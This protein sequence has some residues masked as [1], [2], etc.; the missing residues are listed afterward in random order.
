[1][2]TQSTRSLSAQFHKIQQQ[3]DN[4]KPGK[5]I[6]NTKLNGN[7]HKFK[8]QSHGKSIDFNGPE[9]LVDSFRQASENGKQLEDKYPAHKEFFERIAKLHWTWIDQMP[10][11]S[12]RIDRLLKLDD[13]E[14]NQVFVDTLIRDSHNLLNQ[15]LDD[16]AASLDNGHAKQIKIVKRLIYQAHDNY[17]VLFNLLFSILEMVTVQKYGQSR[18]ATWNYNPSLNE[19]KRIN[20]QIKTDRHKQF[21]RLLEL[22][23][24][25]VLSGLYKFFDFNSYHLQTMPYSRHTVEHGKFDPNNYTFTEFMQLVLLSRNIA[26]SLKGE[27]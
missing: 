15:N 5:I 25:D 4:S 26:V 10:L 14:L 9:W 13:H 17:I 27:K 1:M 12:E 2:T 11:N 23:E 3:I 7:Q 18:T 21:G 24:L 20:E 22:N 6:A 8:V 16:L 19:I